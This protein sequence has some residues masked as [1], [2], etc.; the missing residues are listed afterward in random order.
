MA[1]TET[2]KTLTLSKELQ[3]L[4]WNRLGANT[5]SAFHC[6]DEEIEAGSSGTS[7]S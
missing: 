6:T 7:L 1:R 3:C 2:C 4:P 5:V